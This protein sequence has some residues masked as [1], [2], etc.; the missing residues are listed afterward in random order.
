MLPRLM[1]VFLASVLCVFSSAS[2]A[3][4]LVLADGGKSDYQIVLADNASPSTRHGAEELQ[5]FLRQITGATL[6][7]VSDRKPTGPHEIILGDN[8]HL[9]QLGV[10][11]DFK[12]LGLEGYVIQTVGE[13]LVI[14]GGQVRGNLYGVYGF[15]EDHLGCRWFTPNVSRI[16]KICAVGRPPDQ[17]AADTGAGIPRAVRVRLLRPRLVRAEPH[18]HELRQTG[19]EARRQDEVFDAR[20][21]V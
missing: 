19:R 18:E 12:S 20:T 14:A 3:A 17:R 5:S 9:R 10:A 16:P 4:D 7:I 2:R 13:H 11:V 21:H 6:P 1:S 15:L 8:A